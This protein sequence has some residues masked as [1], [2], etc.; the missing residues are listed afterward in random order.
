LNQRDIGRLKTTEINF[1]RRTAGYILLD[2][3]KNE[4]ILEE[5]KVDPVENKLAQ[6]K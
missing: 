5:I 1:M 6:Y 4:D 2:H 3:R